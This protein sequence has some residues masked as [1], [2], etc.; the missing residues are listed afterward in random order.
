MKKT[1]TAIGVAIGI[2]AG[3]AVSPLFAGPLSDCIT[4]NCESSNGPCDD[5]ECNGI[6]DPYE[7]NKCQIEHAEDCIECIL[8]CCASFGHPGC[9]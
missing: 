9:C 4:N 2:G 3:L 6:S 8:D 7:K 5:S 1:S